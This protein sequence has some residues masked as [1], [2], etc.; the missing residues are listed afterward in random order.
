MKLETQD[1]VPIKQT[2]SVNMYGDNKGIWLSMVG[3]GTDKVYIPI[4]KVFQV[5]RGLESYVQRFY[6][7]RVK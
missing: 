1:L 4:S 3:Y 6:R 7:R 2:K 5:K